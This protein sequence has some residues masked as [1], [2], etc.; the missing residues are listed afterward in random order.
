MLQDEMLVTLGY[1]VNRGQAQLKMLLELCDND[2]DKLMI[3]IAGHSR[4]WEASIFTLSM[5]LGILEG[6]N[7]QL[8]KVLK[9]T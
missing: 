6:M 8:N 9:I 3:K 5:V 2:M 7:E 1:M 4:E